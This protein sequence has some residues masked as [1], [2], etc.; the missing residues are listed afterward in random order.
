MKNEA[1]KSDLSIDRL[2]TLYSAIGKLIT[3]SL[4][5]TDII[6]T[7]MDQ[8]ELF[9][10][11]DNW[12]MMRFD[13]EKNDLYFVIVKGIDPEVVRGFRL[14]LGEG[15]AGQV[16]QRGKSTFIHD[17]E[18]D[19][20]FTQKID[21]LSG[22]KT[23]SIIA[24]PLQFKGQILG[25]IELINTCE[26]RLF[27]KEEFHILETIAD[28]SAIALNNAMTHERIAWMAMH[29]PLT[30]LY[31]YSHLDTFLQKNNC[32][33]HS[34]NNANSPSDRQY[35]IVSLIDI[36]NFKEVND[37]HGHY[38]GDQVLIKTAALIQEI[39]RD[40]DIAVRIGGDEFLIVIIGLRERD[41][42]KTSE[43]VQKK[44]HHISHNINPATGLSFGL[45]TGKIS[46][47]QKLIKEA[48]KQMYFQKRMT[49]SI[50]NVR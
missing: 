41:L 31:N 36:N 5:I 30:K 17:V 28:F 15:I 18:N 32:I 24:V 6:R 27:T 3:G 37:T 9:F 23:R 47:M 1:N 11:P 35:V 7:I 43:R 19:P 50:D 22:F 13:F 49:K 42:D 46:D 26:D 29:D 12:S 10:Q 33:S 4:D 8:I 45:V 34:P 40:K 38:V 2:L 14:K 20:D 44:L 21:N 39:C 48:D 16:A 25:V